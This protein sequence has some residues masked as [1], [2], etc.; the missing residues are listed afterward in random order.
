MW[1]GVREGNISLC[2]IS[3]L[4]DRGGYIKV[5]PQS[6]SQLWVNTEIKRK[7]GIESD[8]ALT[9]YESPKHLATKHI[10]VK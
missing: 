5:T 6:S 4:C 10:T 2:R 3:G 8:F 9:E 1:G 7:A